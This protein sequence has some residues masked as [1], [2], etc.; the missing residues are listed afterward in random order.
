MTLLPGQP[1][2]H[3]ARSYSPYCSSTPGPVLATGL[4]GPIGRVA[5][6]PDQRQGCWERAGTGGGAGGCGWLEPDRHPSAG[7]QQGAA[8]RLIWRVSPACRCCLHRGRRGWLPA[9]DC[10]KQISGLGALRRAKMTTVSASVPVLGESA[11]SGFGRGGPPGE[12]AAVRSAAG[13]ADSLGNTIAAPLPD[14]TVSAGGRPR[15]RAAV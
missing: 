9:Y 12:A 3:R 8:A 2:S 13:R 4:Q 1:S 15:L 7:L 6:F 11:S 5:A 10:G 14:T